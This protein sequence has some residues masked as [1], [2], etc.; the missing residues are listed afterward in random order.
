V[1]GE[2][3]GAEPGERSER[4][5]H[6]LL[7]GVTGFL[8]KVV[9]HELLRR[10]DELGITRV[11]AV[12]RGK[13]RTA[14]EDRFRQQVIA[15]PCFANAPA[16]WWDAVAVVPGELSQPD[17][18]LGDAARR[19]LSARI[20][21]V[22]HCAA[23]VDFDLPLPQAASANVDSA[24]HVLELARECPHLASFVDV[25]TA[26]VTPHAS[27]AAIIPE[28]LAPLPRPAADLHQEIRAGAHDAPEAEA[29][30][31][32]ETGHPNTYTLTKCMAEHRL[33]ERGG[34]PLTLVRPS[35]ISAATARPFPD[36][37]DSA[38]GFSLFIIAVATRRMRVLMAKPDARVDLI[39]VDAVADRVI[40]AAFAP[41][42]A[43]GAPRILHAVAGYEHNPS[44]GLCARRVS[45]HFARHP[46]GDG[47]TA[48]LR[49]VGPSGP[50]YR[51][52]HRVQHGLRPLSRPVADRLDAMNQ[53]F[54]YF[55]HH[56]FRFASSVPF[57]PPGF[58][59]D[60]YIDGVSRGIHRHLLAAADAAASERSRPAA[61][62]GGRALPAQPGDA[63]SARPWLV[64]GASGFVGRHLLEACAQ[65]GAPRCLALVR[66]PDQWS[67]EAWTHGLDVERVRGSVTG[68]TAW[69]A[70]LPRLGAIAHLAAVVRHSRRDPG[71]RMHET[72][73]EGTLAMVR[74]AAAH[75]CRL[76]VVS[77]SGTVGCF[78]DA[79]RHADE[80]SPFC[81][82]EVS[83]W[84]YYASKIELERRARAL[85][86][87]LG[88]ELVLV[89]PP[90]L[91]GPGDHRFRSTG[92]VL[93]FLRGKLPFLIRGGI[94]FAD[95]RDAA[96]AIAEALARGDVRPVYH[97]P[98]T[99][100]GIEEFF[101]MVSEVSGQP[102]PRFV[103][104]FRPAWLL[105][106]AAAPLHVLPDPVVIEMAAHHWGARSL[107][108]AE[109]GYKSREPRETLR[110]TVE[111]LRA[112]HEALRSGAPGLPQR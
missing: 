96:A 70:G 59:P 47:P 45:R 65:R 38:A 99:E 75:R 29:R 97:L 62:A 69:T 24:L 92:N 33:V 18:G 64:T 11:H 6:V 34:V 80:T 56:T 100:C 53:V 55:T 86:D 74:L 43:P 26:Y 54:A 111:W 81:E 109:L 104:P 35:I 49:Y 42:P 106:R 90:I 20:T 57:D 16:D 110:D 76:V 28:A 67:R 48:G 39:P 46:V 72:N 71:D 85:A 89:R 82:R 108:A 17:A 63:A 84:P 58:R 87:E 2:R 36:W 32:A 40:G 94:H 107:Y 102:V 78:R 21:H 98:G 9:L 27:D 83:R 60:R 23:S 13:R 103:L 1:Q 8:G 95:V 77:S 68:A 44:V 52:Q 112:N 37:I 66:D 73:V 14:P 50:V 3:R 10:R 61:P 5:A 15:S 31:L 88:V 25:S 79:D 51:L 30:L 101:A 41:P 19:E 12:V 93:R 7:T 22:I 105:A 4:G 91:L